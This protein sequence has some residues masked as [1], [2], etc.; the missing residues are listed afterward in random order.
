MPSNINAEEIIIWKIMNA[1]DYYEILEVTRTCTTDEIKKAYRRLA[2]LVHPDKNKEKGSEEAFKALSAAFSC[3]S[4]TWTRQQYDLGLGSTA[5][6][7]EDIRRRAEELSR[8]SVVELFS[9]F[10]NLFKDIN[11]SLW[12]F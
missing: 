3:L 4:E 9:I 5:E 11:K 1:S 10:N 8:V 12:G 2:L 7:Q 6:V